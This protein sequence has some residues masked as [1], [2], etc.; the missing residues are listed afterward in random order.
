[1]KTRELIQ[2]LTDLKN[3]FQEIRRIQMLLC[4]H[5]EKLQWWA[6]VLFAEISEVVSAYPKVDEAVYSLLKCKVAEFEKLVVSNAL[7]Q[8]KKALE[9]AEEKVE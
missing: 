3:N 7:E 4:E 1:M 6:M 2:A 5:D 8:A 9:K